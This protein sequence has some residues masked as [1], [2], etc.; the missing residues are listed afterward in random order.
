MKEL[1]EVMETFY[2]ACD[3]GYGVC[4]F[5]KT[6]QRALLK[7]RM[8]NNGVLPRNKKIQTTDTCNNVGKSHRYHD[9]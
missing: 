1:W 2:L 3:G 8:D 6:H 5:I 9:E 4:T 7:W